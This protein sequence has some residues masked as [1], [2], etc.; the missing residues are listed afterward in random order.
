VVSER[1]RSNFRTGIYI[2]PLAGLPSAATES[3]NSNDTGGS[4]TSSTST[5]PINSPALNCS[6]PTTTT[7]NAT[8]KHNHSSGSR[9]TSVD[10]SDVKKNK[11]IENSIK[12]RIGGGYG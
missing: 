12:V 1:E 7:I 3:N 11:A 6:A 4:P 9:S 8:S 5:S 2:S 10:Y